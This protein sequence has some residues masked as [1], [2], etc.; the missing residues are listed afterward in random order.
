MR[1]HESTMAPCTHHPI[2]SERKRTII[3]PLLSVLKEMRADQRIIVLQHFDDA[4]RDALYEVIEHALCDSR[5]PARR[6]AR[7]RAK[8]MPHKHEW[9]YVLD[10]SRPPAMRKRKLLQLGG[11]PLS[12][13]LKAAVPFLLDIF[14]LRGDANEEE[15]PKKE[16]KEPNYAKRIGKVLIRTV[17]GKKKRGR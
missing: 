16:E 10:R 8:L 11:G 1:S 6:R 15:D 13:I 12:Y 9:R 17:R 7:L 2:L 4:T 5:L 14:L 3:L